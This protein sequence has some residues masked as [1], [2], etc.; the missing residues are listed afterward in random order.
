VTGNPLKYVNVGQRVFYKHS[1]RWIPF[2]VTHA[3]GVTARI[4]NTMVGISRWVDLSELREAP[5]ILQ[6]VK[7]LNGKPIVDVI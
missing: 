3:A 1:N 5:E 6:A 4:E 7:S 2:E